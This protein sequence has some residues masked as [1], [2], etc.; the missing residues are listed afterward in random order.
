MRISH[1][2]DSVSFFHSHK[3]SMIRSA[4]HRTTQRALRHNAQLLIHTSAYRQL[5]NDRRHEEFSK[6]FVKTLKSLAE[7]PQDPVEI[8]EAT[9]NADATLS[10]AIS[11]LFGRNKVEVTPELLER[12]KQL[13]EKYPE[14]FRDISDEELDK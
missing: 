4:A 7:A 9:R 8:S 1:P 12:R 5:P 2:Y 3:D 11:G 6:G 10:K 13:R 14:L